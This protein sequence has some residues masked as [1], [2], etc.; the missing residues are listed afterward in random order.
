MSL[1]LKLFVLSYIEA[2]ISLIEFRGLISFS[3][4]VVL[5]LF[6]K[7]IPT[8]YFMLLFLYVSFPLMSSLQQV[9]LFKWKFPV[10]LSILFMLV[11]ILVLTN[12]MQADSSTR[13]FWRVC[14]CMLECERRQCLVFWFAHWLILWTIVIHAFTCKMSWKVILIAS[15]FLL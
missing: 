11:T 1:E 8:F 12:A 3:L 10:T 7:N 5:V 9:T 6:L 2:C 13:V 4:N 15:L 14:S